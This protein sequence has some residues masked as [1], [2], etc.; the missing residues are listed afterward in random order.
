MAGVRDGERLHGE[1]E[2]L[3][4]GDGSVEVFV[5]VED[6]ELFAA[7]PVRGVLGAEVGGEDRG[8]LL[9]RGVAVAVAVGVVVG[10]EVVEVAHR[11]A[12][13]AVVAP[14]AGVER[15]EVFLEPA[16]VAELG[17]RV[18]TCLL[19]ELAV[20]SFELRPELR[21]LMVQRGDALGRDRAASARR[22]GRA[23]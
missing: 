13:R 14:S 20:E 2:T 6:D 19:G 21:E 10:L 17:E 12:V 9:E 11:D 3:G 15:G 5:R 8:D 16:A 4:R 22:T 18:G 7:V 1:A 23:A